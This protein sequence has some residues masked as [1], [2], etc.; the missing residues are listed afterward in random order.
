V[1][2]V[3]RRPVSRKQARRD[4]LFVLYQHEV[5][6]LPVASL[7]ENLRR[8][9]GY[10]PDEFTQRLVTGVF[11]DREQLDETLAAHCHN[12]PLSRLA[13]LERSA[14]RLALFEMQGDETPP[15]VAISEAVRLI[16]RYA[17][18]EAG[19]LVNGVLGAIQTE[20]EGDGAQ[21]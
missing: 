18:A 6:A 15:E 2:G 21:E 10:A 20:R 7:M 17:S 16:K 5:T 4:A 8:D 19:S 14:L 9:Q 1:V 3:A 12:W 13:P 11:G